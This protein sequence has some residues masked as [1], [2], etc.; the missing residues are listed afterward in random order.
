VVG[1]ADGIIGDGETPLTQVEGNPRPANL[2]VPGEESLRDGPGIVQP[3][4][5][6]GEI[7]FQPA[8]RAEWREMASRWQR[9]AA[10]AAA[11]CLLRHQDKE[12]YWN[13]LLTADATLESDYILLQLW[14]NPPEGRC[15]PASAQPRIRKAVRAILERQL[16]DGGWNIY[17]GGPS[18]VNATSRA[19]IAMKLAGEPVDSRPMQAARRGVLSLR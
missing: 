15:W 16:P 5:E 13:G 4:P 1:R 10:P 17:A 11:G 12:G 9:E 2:P 18:E 7:A 19:Y 3:A 8:A 6:P 14:L